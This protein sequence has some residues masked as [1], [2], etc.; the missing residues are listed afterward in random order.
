MARHLISRGANVNICIG[1]NSGLTGVRGNSPLHFACSAIERSSHS[2]MVSLLLA[3]GA[4]VN[5]RNARGDTPLAFAI[6]LEHSGIELAGE[7]WLAVVTSLLKGG[8]SLDACRGEMTAENLFFQSWDS[9]EIALHFNLH[10]VK[11]L[12]D[13]VRKHGSYK[14]YVRAPHR[15]VL[16]CRGL[17]IR[18]KLRT[19]HRAL[20]FIAKQ[21]DNGVVWNILSYWRAAD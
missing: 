1:N 3:A 14:R 4:N 15:D 6:A 5:S 2:T 19:D 11:K 13:G 17:A 9:H 16:A 12:I 20:A 7:D 10:P 18:G 21:G 8:A